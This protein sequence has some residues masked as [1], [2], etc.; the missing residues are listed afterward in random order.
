M[1][2]LGLALLGI[3]LVSFT[4]SK[5]LSLYHQS[6]LSSSESSE[7]NESSSSEEVTVLRATSN[8][9]ELNT[10]GP[11]SLGDNLPQTNNPT[12]HPGL[13]QTTL[14]PSLIEQ[15]IVEFDLNISFVPLEPAVPVTGGPSAGKIV[16][17]D[18]TTPEL[19]CY[20]VPLISSEP[21]PARGDNI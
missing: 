20:T 11:G 7:S 10:I 4:V 19:R 3:F 17:P 8:P 2:G 1:D 15:E 21:Q 18:V 5:P 9:V 13:V 14:D 16:A 6:T 12:A